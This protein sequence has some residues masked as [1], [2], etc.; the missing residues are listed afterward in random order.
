MIRQ[1]DAKITNSV[2]DYNSPTSVVHT[3]NAS[4]TSS[5]L[6]GNAGDDIAAKNVNKN[7]CR[8]D[9]ALLHRNA[10]HKCS[11]EQWHS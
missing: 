2:T 1:K 11:Q 7:S 9:K 6:H 4:M 3:E 5:R 10:Q 8:N